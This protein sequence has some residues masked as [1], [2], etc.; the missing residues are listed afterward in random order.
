MYTIS[1]ANASFS[2]GLVVIPGAAGGILFGGWVGD[3]FKLSTRASALFSFVMPLLSMF[4]LLMLFIGCP[5]NPL[6]GTVS[7]Y[8]LCSVRS[9]AHH[10][11]CVGDRRARPL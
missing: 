5:N 9:G 8:V 3:R 4:L 11:V 2:V 7:H 6:A 1:A 10:T